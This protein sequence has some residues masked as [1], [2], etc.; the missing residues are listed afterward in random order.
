MPRVNLPFVDSLSPP[1]QALAATV[2]TWSLTALGASLVFLTR[3]VS[4][5]LLNMAQG[6][7]AGVMLPSVWIFRRKCGWSGWGTL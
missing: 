2:F 1:M 5:R 3:S 4:G 7:A 6:F